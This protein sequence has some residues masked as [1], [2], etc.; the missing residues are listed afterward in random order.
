M[1]WI[2]EV[3]YSI[4]QLYENVFIH[5]FVDGHLDHFQFLVNNLAIMNKAAKNIIKYFCVLLTK[6]SHKSVAFLL[7]E[8]WHLFFILIMWTVSLTHFDQYTLAEEMPCNLRKYI[9][10]FHLGLLVECSFLEPNGYAMRV[11]SCVQ[12][13]Y[14]REPRHTTWYI[15][16]PY[17]RHPGTPADIHWYQLSSQ[18]KAQIDSHVRDH[19]VHGS[20]AKFQMAAIF[21]FF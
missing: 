20:P 4:I 19:L 12:R 14:G 8:M 17:R 1:P 16:R 18:L 15:Q 6:D 5:S 11:L 10:S 2:I 13:P 7:I 21:I 9:F 3:K